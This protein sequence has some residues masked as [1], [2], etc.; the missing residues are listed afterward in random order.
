MALPVLVGGLGDRVGIGS[1]PV[2]G[3]SKLK[4]H[5]QACLVNDT[6]KWSNIPVIAVALINEHADKMT[7]ITVGDV[8]AI[9]FDLT[10][11]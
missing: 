9:F 3:R 11:E 10:R 1:V 8:D 4:R 2:L 6:R 5:K 7:K